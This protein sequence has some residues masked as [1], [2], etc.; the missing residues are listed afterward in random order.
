MSPD[1]LEEILV[2]TRPTPDPA[3][4][5]ELDERVERGFRKA[6]VAG[7]RRR[8]LGRPVLIPALGSVAT[9]ALVVIIAVTVPGD[10]GDG[11]TGVTS[12]PG[13][14]GA[15]TTERIEPSTARPDEATTQ[16]APPALPEPEP[17]APVPGDDRKVEHLAS[18]SLST[19]AED[20]PAVGDQVVRLTD[21]LGGY[22]AASSVTMSDDGGGGTFDLKV[23][24][25]RLD[26]AM[27]ELSRL[28]HVSERTQSSNDITGAF[29]AARARLREARAERQALLRQLA[30]ARTPNQTASIR[31]RLRAVRREINAALRERRQVGRRAA[32][33][34]IAVT[35]VADAD[36]PGAGDEEDGAWTPGDAIRDALR[37][38]E[39]AA[40]VAI[41]VLAAVLPLALLLAGAALAARRLVRHR[42][43]TALDAAA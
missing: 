13:A 31:A 40:G 14:G 19:P 30:R 17:R 25:G 28:A 10:S 43:E 41:L 37:V 12:V 7:R 9:V 21:R 22:V 18:L 27:A 5:A 33:A 35:L 2:E 11:L 32:Y 15:G 4:A 38:L 20:V 29:D 24:V 8:L 1:L 42:R 16:G 34:T 39:V 36:A 26:R 6:P 23:P 3:W